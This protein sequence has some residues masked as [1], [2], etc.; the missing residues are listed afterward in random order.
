MEAIVEG[1]VLRTGDQVRVTAQLIHA[2]TDE[3]LWAERFDRELTNILAL[4]SDVARAIAGEIRAAL[5]PWRS[6]GAFV[7]SGTE[8]RRQEAFPACPTRRFATSLT[9]V[10][11]SK[12]GRVPST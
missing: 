7:R 5:T 1:S 12:H 10:E 2:A 4:H 3:L 8:I 6:V 11:R 9:S